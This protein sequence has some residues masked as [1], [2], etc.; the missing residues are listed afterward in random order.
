M[1]PKRIDF[2]SI[3][4][5]H[6]ATLP[7]FGCNIIKYIYTEFYYR[8]ELRSCDLSRYRQKVLAAIYV[9]GIK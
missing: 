7:C 8:S 1:P 4:L 3:A 5:D 9:H 2:E 6:S